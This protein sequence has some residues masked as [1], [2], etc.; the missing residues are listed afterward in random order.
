MGHPSGR[1]RHAVSGQ[2]ARYV[3]RVVNHSGL[4]RAVSVED[5]HP[6]GGKLPMRYAH[7]AAIPHADIDVRAG[8]TQPRAASRPQL[9]GGHRVC[10]RRVLR[11]V[12]KRDTVLDFNNR[13]DPAILLVD[14]RGKPGA[15][16]EF[17]DLLL[18]QSRLLSQLFGKGEQLG[19]GD[20]RAAG[21]VRDIAVGESFVGV[22]PRNNLLLNPRP[23]SRCRFLGAL[24]GDGRVN[25][26]TCGALRPGLGLRLGHE[27]V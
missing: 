4:A 6:V 19:V 3:R 18:V 12:G 15:L 8:E 17:L 24:F 27:F 25:G 5:A 14:D 26:R 21:V 7:V 13:G 2:S 23:P 11:R 20:R 9:I 10:R 22:K 16:G 1:G